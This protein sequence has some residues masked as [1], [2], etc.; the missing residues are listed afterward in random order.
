MNR[1]GENF[2]NFWW[3]NLHETCF[4]VLTASKFVM[5]WN[6]VY[7]YRVRGQETLRFGLTFSTFSYLMIV[8]ILFYILQGASNILGSFF[9]CLPFSASL[10]RSLIQQAVGGKTQLASLVSC[11]LLLFVLLVIGPFFEPLPNVSY[12]NRSIKLLS[13]NFLWNVTF[14]FNYYYWP[15]WLSLDV[16][17]ETCELLFWL[18]IC[19][20]CLSI[21]SSSSTVAYFQYISIRSNH[22]YIDAY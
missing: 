5:V 12:M 16:W 21:S 7:S 15:W 17:P 10:S 9:S 2:W 19:H 3:W 18:P 6:G 1:N 4:C 14:S 13:L 20:E 8:G 22:R 11:I